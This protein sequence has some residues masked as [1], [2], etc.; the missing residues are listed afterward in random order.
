MKPLPRAIAAPELLDEPH[1]DPAELRHSLAH[2]AA[3]NRWLGGTRA[4]LR[5]LTPYLESANKTRILDV[6]TASGDLPRN[7][8][9]WARSHGC[10]VE[11]VATDVHPQMRQVARQRLHDFPE[12]TIGAADGRALPYAD[13]SFDIALLCLTLHHFDEAEQVRIV[14][15]LARVARRAVLISELRRT[16]LNYIGAQLLAQ[17]IWRRNRLT[18]HDGPLSVLR[19]FTADELLGL[20]REAGLSGHV[21]E[22]YFQRA[23]LV[24]DPAR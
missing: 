24:I 10:V 8:A 19:A 9:R 1:H 20:A 5:H 17:T 12:I 21:H 16:R 18:R 23:V 13:R 11:I 7:V 6:G 22:H 14:H 3:V 2:V 4:L 15:E